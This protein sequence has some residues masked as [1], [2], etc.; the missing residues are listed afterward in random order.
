ML[1]RG[2]KELDRA[3][4]DLDWESQVYKIDVRIFRNV[5]ERQVM[6]EILAR[7]QTGSALGGR[8]GST[9]KSNEL[10]ETRSFQ[11]LEG[12]NVSN[13]SEPTAT[14][15]DNTDR[16]RHE[17]PRRSEEGGTTGGIYNTCAEPRS[18]IR[19]AS[20]SRRSGRS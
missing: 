1:A 17:E 5:F 7:I 9:A 11:S 16:C 19:H 6:L 2:E 4:H 15:E 13:T 18:S 14:H 20:P 8:F 10:D 3:R 12:W